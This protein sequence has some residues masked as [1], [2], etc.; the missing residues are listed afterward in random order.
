MSEYTPFRSGHH[1]INKNEKDAAPRDEARYAQYREQYEEWPGQNKLG[2]FPTHLDIELSS[3]CN[4]HCPMCHTLYIEDPSF[5][6]FKDN[7]MD[8]ALLDFDMF[9][10]AI[11]EAVQYEHFHSIKLNYRGEST[12]HPQ[13]VDCIRYAKEKGVFDIMLNTNG[14]YPIELTELMVDAGLTWLSV[15][16]DSIRPETYKKVRAGGNFYR[17][18]A[19]AID[20]CRFADRVNCHVSFVK[21]KA[22]VDEIDQFVEF[23]D[24]MP[25][26]KMLISDVY[27]PGELIKNDSAITVLNYKRSDSF[28]CPQLW[29]RILM[30]NDGRMFPCCHAFEAPDDLYLGNI[31]DMNIRDAWHSEKLNNL[32]DI[33]LKGNYQD[34]DTCYRCAYPK[35]PVQLTID[36]IIQ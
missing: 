4:L 35:E 31:K 22:N 21:Q 33:H 28:T 29:Q 18:Y 5:G 8:E 6:K 19:T 17:A 7:R 36:N 15:S 16:L 13:I 27:N 25:L 3:A 11:D 12:L 1:Y 30:F 9:K 20:M 34:I 26:K 14:N 2:D 23:W 32:R 10:K 24:R